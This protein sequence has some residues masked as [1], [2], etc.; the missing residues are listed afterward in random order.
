M[1]AIVLTD[2][3][4]I[5]LVERPVPVAGPD[6]VLLRVNACG[7]CGTDLHAPSMSD[8]FATDVVLGHEFSGTIVETGDG[9]GDLAAGDEV[10]VNPIA[11]A[12]GT[13]EACQRGLSNQCL[14]ALTQ[15]CGVAKDG[16]MAEFVAVDRRHVHHVPEGVAVR[17]AAW[18]EPLAVAVRAVGLGSVHAG[19]SIAILGAGAIGQLILQVALSAG[20][21][22][23]LVVEPSVYRREV[24]RSCGASTVVSPDQASASP[25]LYDVVFDCTGVSA[26]LATALAL[27]GHGGRVVVAGSYT[28]PITFDARAASAREASIVFTAVYRDHLEFATA[29]RL[30]ERAVIDVSPLTTSILPITRHEE[31]FSSLRN[32]EQ[33][34]KILLDPSIP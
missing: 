15:T 6:A 18:T 25:R 29:L 10:V 8:M 14:T 16:G 21:G 22:E 19:A 26:A 27:V 11:L 34:V 9:V 13:C 5:R 1:K 32:P 33:A 28:S 30:L 2:D 31:A 4:E 24:A 20:A 12:C 17:D 3:A 7:I 23:S